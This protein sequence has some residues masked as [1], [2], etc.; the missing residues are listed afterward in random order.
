MFTISSAVFPRRS[1][2]GALAAAG[3]V[4][5]AAIEVEVAAAG[6]PPDAGVKLSVGFGAPPRVSVGAGLVVAAVVPKN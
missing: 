6:T 4:V 1:E 5:V 2:G 3:A